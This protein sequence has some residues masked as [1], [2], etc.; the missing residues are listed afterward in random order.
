LPSQLKT[1]INKQKSSEIAP[2]TSGPLFQGDR[3]MPASV[4]SDQTMPNTRGQSQGAPML[5]G[6][7]EQDAKAFSDY[8]LKGLAHLDALP[9]RAKRSAAEHAEVADLLSQARASRG[10]FLHAHASRLY[11]EMTDDLQS[12]R[13]VEELAVQA[14]DRV[15]GLCPTPAR[16]ATEAAL[17]QAEK[18][19]HEIDQGILFNYILG[20]ETCGRHLCHAMLLP[21]KE[22]LD[23]L[24]E[25]KRRGRVD[26]AHASVERK[27]KASIV[28]M[29]NSRH[30]N[31]EDETTLKDV[32]TAVDLAILDPE[33]SICVLRGDVIEGGKY[34]GKR[35]FCT[36]INLTH[37]YYGRI[38]FMWYLVRDLGFINKIYRGM[39]KPDILPD[40][41]Y[42]DTTEKPWITAVE[43]F[44][45]GGGCQYLLVTDYNIAASD[46]YMTLP[47]RKEGIIPGVANMR[48]PRFVGDRIARQ[49][50]MSERRIECDSDAGRM[51][52]DLIVEPD[53]MDQA[54]DDVILRLT[55]SG[56]VNASSNR[57]AFR[58]TQEPLDMFRKY[59]A[60]YSREQA[61]CHFSPALISNL[62]RFWNAQQRK[63]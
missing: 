23:R 14:A 20:D 54:I 28:L 35:V 7:Y 58:V 2:L 19:G 59:M 39:A 40:E 4:S 1:F 26:L 53:Q 62:E 57:K 30:L 11:R 56:A 12:F 41:I 43:K 61:Y 44:A 45:I 36:G 46:A 15:P 13:R 51:I 48:L 17:V 8:W 5:T 37:I 60:V 10:A 38:S 6:N 22:A 50:I 29:K 63:L 27:G 49:A 3:Q 18:D 21:R 47:A 55:N 52:C 42:G 31:A 9:G 33:T 25:L 16:V 24:E 34:D 32:E